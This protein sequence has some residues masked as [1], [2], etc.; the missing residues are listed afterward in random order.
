MLAAITLTVGA[1]GIANTTLV[2]VL[3]RTAE[4]G[5][6]RALGARPRHIALQFLTESTAIGTLGGLLGT[7]LGV[8][9]V[10]LS[11]LL[12][13]WTAILQP[14]AVVAAPLVGALVGLV[15]GVY[16]ALRAAWVEPVEA[17]RR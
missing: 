9:V 17:L 11:A 15:A 5:L 8:A 13:Q 16:P 12:H 10:V 4:I 6:R 3:E 1:V 7:S 2:A 14:W